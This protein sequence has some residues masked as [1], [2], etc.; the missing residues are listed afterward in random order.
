MATMIRLSVEQGKSV[1]VN[2]D[3]ILYIEP[4][5]PEKGCQIY[6]GLAHKIQATESAEAIAEKAGWRPQKMSAQVLKHH[7]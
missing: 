3:S 7:P 4:G 2:A 5:Q 6:F 1:F